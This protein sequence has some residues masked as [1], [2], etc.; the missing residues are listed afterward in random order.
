MPLLSTRAASSAIG[1]GFSAG[2]AP[3]GSAVYTTPG[4]YSWV[5]P[6]GVKSVSIVAIGAGGNGSGGGGGLGYKN[7]YSVTPGNSYTVVVGTPN[8][9]AAY[10]TYFVNYCNVRGGSG[11]GYG[12]NSATGGNYT[13]DSGGNGGRGGIASGYAGGGA[14]GYA[15]N[16]GAAATCS[17]GSGSAGSGGG[18]GGGGNS[19]G[20]GGGGGGVCLFGQGPSGSGGTAGQGGRGGSGGCNG[21]VASIYDSLGGLYGGGGGKR[22]AC[23]CSG[24]GGCGAVRIIWPGNKRSFPS[25][26]GTPCYPSAPT[27]GTATALNACGSVSVSFCAPSCYGRAG[28]IISYTATS[29]P[30]CITATGS[31][32]PITVSGLTNCTSYTF[33]VKASNYLGAGACSLASNSATPKAYNSQAYITTGTYSWVAPAGVTS[34]SVVAIGSGNRSGGGLGYKNNISVT[35]GNSYSVVVSDSGC[36]A[37]YFCRSSLVSGVSGQTNA[38]GGYV[39]DGGGYGGTKGSGNDGGGGGAGGYSGNGG[40]GGAQYNSKG[41]DGAIGSGAAGG[42]GG[43][44][45]GPASQAGGASGGGTGL[46]GRGAYGFGG[47]APQQFCFCCNGHNK[48]FGQSYGGGAGSGGSGGGGVLVILDYT[49]GVWGVQNNN[50]G[51][52]Y[53]G[54]R[55]NS[56]SYAPNATD[57]KGAVRIVWPGNTRQ[58]PTTCVGSP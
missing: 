35:P 50:H 17:T 25:S 4:T 47:S 18:A 24:R 2:V 27:I 44:G 9:N 10:P 26:C 58:F 7:N 32:S 21:G 30:G 22:V 53:G 15:G 36:A 11:Y 29:T 39:G 3:V 48:G 20:I 12:V 43:G 8:Q 19:G 28:K 14:G 41:S 31:S 56:T 33:K 51:G 57:G 13:G 5:A 54:G 42:G 52:N 6:V 1:L 46:L 37:S 38:G 40:D 49:T 34:V 23:Y 16:G 45:V 55:G